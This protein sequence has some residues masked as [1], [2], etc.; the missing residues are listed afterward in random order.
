MCI[1]C[2]IL[3]IH[4]ILLYTHTYHIMS[5]YHIYIYIFP[6]SQAFLELP[7]DRPTVPSIHELIPLP[8]PPG[9]SQPRRT[10][11][12]RAPRAAGAAGAAG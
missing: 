5:V 7:H 1:F 8:R 6:V 11:P 10:P 3:D 12:L 2:T 9:A 4:D